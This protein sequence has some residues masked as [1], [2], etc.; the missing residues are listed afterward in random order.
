MPIR[1]LGSGLPVVGYLKIGEASEKASKLK[2]APYRFDHIEVTGRQRDP[3]GR[4]FLD[5]FATAKLIEQGAATCGGCERS[6]HLAEVYDEPLF[7]A[8]LPTQIP[9][10]LPYDS[11][12]LDLPHRLA[13][14]K[15]RTAYCTGDGEQAMRLTV[16]GQRSVDGKDVPTYGPAEPF[17][18]C[19]TTCPDLQ[20]RRCKPHGKFRCV[21][22]TQANV[23]G[24]YE[25]QTTS[26]NSLRNLAESL[27]MIQA[28]TRGKLAWI[29]LRFEISPQTVQ[30]REGGRAN[31]A[32]IARVTFPGSPQQLLGVV[33]EQLAIE[34]PLHAEIRQL[35][36]TIRG[37]A[38][39]TES[40]DEITAHRAEFA[41][42]ADDDVI[43]ALPEPE[44]V[45]EPASE[46]DP[47]A[48]PAPASPRTGD[49][50]ADELRELAAAAATRAA[51]LFELQAAAKLPCVYATAPDVALALKIQG[52]AAFGLKGKAIPAAAVTLL[53]EYWGRCVLDPAGK[54]ADLSAGPF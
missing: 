38:Q 26:W 15:G 35:E 30:P 1:I 34:A 2:G 54:L 44:G 31:I 22:A 28:A 49:A 41:A 20:A 5:P 18:P 52:L 11:L 48:P 29:P 27:R 39:W 51:E 16:T 46:P 50:N 13:Y 23:G 24:C 17:G 9:I 43:D 45:V 4:L 42:G 8:G 36:A 10:L 21:L 3:E 37:E 7:V 12:D 25:F 19:G 53:V 14:Y 40:P 33:R 32:M 47:E 6:K